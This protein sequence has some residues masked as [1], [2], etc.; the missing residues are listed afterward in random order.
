MGGELGQEIV[1]RGVIYHA[2]LSGIRRNELRPYIQLI[3]ELRF[4]VFGVGM[5][6]AF[7][8]AGIGK[9]RGVA[10]NAAGRDVF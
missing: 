10:Q 6:Q 7:D 1:S 3:G 2:L 5:F 8:H 9:R 4:G